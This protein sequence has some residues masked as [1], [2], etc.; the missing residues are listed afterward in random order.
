MRI[1]EH[2]PCS[3][4]L[5]DVLICHSSRFGDRQCR[6]KQSGFDLVPSSLLVQGV[7]A[8]DWTGA[9]LLPQLCYF[10]LVQARALEHVTLHPKVTLVPPKNKLKAVKRRVSVWVRSL[11]SV[12]LGARLLFHALNQLWQ[13]CSCSDS[14]V[15][16]CCLDLR[17]WHVSIPFHISLYRYTLCIVYYGTSIDGEKHFEV[18]LFVI[19]Y[20]C[21]HFFKM[22]HLFTSINLMEWTNKCIK[23]LLIYLEFSVSFFLLFFCLCHWNYVYTYF[24]WSLLSYLKKYPSLKGLFHCQYKL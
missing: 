7:S 13:L 18:K 3:P 11:N 14:Q 5:C 9:D 20:S 12:K 17:C 16:E 4:F 1:K 6:W 21:V 19:L 8:D 2:C 10:W 15:T 24:L 22:H 23:K